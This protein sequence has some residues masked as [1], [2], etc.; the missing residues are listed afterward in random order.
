MNGLTDRQRQ[1][2]RHIG[3]F[4]QGHGFPPTL[5]EIGDAM[6]IRSTNGV[7]DH[8]RALEQKGFLVRVGFLKSRALRLTKAGRV[9]CYGTDG[10][11]GGTSACPNCGALCVSIFNPKT[12]RA[13]DIRDA[14]DAATT[15]T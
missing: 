4:L 12:L 6:G 14:I 15:G 9:E 1:T 11:G 7:Q 8:I 2:L 3:S 10:E 13:Q 5:R